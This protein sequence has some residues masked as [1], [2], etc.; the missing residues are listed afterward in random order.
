MKK[1]QVIIVSLIL[2][3]SILEIA[4]L[5]TQDKLHLLFFQFGWLAAI[6]AAGYA[7]GQWTRL[8]AIK[9]LLS[10]KNPSTPIPFHSSWFS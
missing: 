1:V 3:S 2:F 6:G 4:A 10:P 5:F 7:G 9:S 8:S